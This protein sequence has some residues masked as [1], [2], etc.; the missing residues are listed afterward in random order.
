MPL[1]FE[2][3]KGYVELFITFDDVVF[4]SLYEDTLGDYNY[5]K[6]RYNI[7][8]DDNWLMALLLIRRA[9]PILKIRNA[10]ITNKKAE[11]LVT[12]I[13]NEIKRTLMKYATPFMSYIPEQ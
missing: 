5:Y 2:K 1:D 12:D 9:R 6:D 8:D 13:D 10:K 4:Q 11:L 7:V 3:V